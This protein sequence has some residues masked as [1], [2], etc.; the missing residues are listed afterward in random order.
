MPAHLDPGITLPGTATEKPRAA[1]CSQVQVQRTGGSGRCVPLH[2]L[3]AHVDAGEQR[4]T[5]WVAQGR[6]ARR[7]SASG[8]LVCTCTK[9]ARTSPKGSVLLQWG[10][11]MSS[12]SSTNRQA[13]AMGLSS[14]RDQDLLVLLLARPQCQ[15]GTGAQELARP[16][17]HSGGGT[18][19][20]G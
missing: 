17:V 5:R 19:E 10:F 9:A 11:A 7:I 8:T 13:V 16:E 6:V 4:P 18:A 3:V 12:C 2:Q 14:G 15:P 1:P 20:Q